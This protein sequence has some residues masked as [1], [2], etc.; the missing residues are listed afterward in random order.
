MFGDGPVIRELNEYYRE[1]MFSKTGAEGFGT[2]SSGRFKGRT[3]IGHR[4]FENAEFI[5]FEQCDSSL[6]EYVMKLL[7]FQRM[8][9]ENQFLINIQRIGISFK[10]GLLQ[11]FVPRKSCFEMEILFR[12]L[13]S[14]SSSIHYLQRARSY[15]FTRVLYLVF[16]KIKSENLGFLSEFFSE[17]Y[18]E[19][20]GRRVEEPGHSSSELHGFSVDGFPER[21][22]AIVSELLN[23]FYIT[24]DE[25]FSIWARMID[26]CL[27]YL[28]IEYKDHI[29]AS[30]YDRQVRSCVTDLIDQ[31]SKNYGEC[32][33]TDFLKNLEV[34]KY[35]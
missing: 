32:E 25:V 16:M 4:V 31:I 9:H 2:E 6:G 7:K 35:L 28:Q 1:G 18:I 24:N 19:E 30:E 8:A 14:I 10:D 20:A 29:I 11:Y 13:F 15:N 22:S 33:F 27:E 5:A 12:F 3:K 17:K 34:E 26:I 23:R 21:F